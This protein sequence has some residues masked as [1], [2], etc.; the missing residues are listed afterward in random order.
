MSAKNLRRSGWVCK[1]SAGFASTGII[2]RERWGIWKGSSLPGEGGGLL[3][4]FILC[5]TSYLS[6]GSLLC[7]TDNLGAGG[8]DRQMG[9]PCIILGLSS[10]PS[11]NRGTMKELLFK[12]LCKKVPVGSFTSCSLEVVQSFF[13]LPPPLMWNTFCLQDLCLHFITLKA[14]AALFYF[15]HQQHTHR[16]KIKN[17][18]WSVV[19][20]YSLMS[21][22]LACFVWIGV[23]L[24][25][26]VLITHVLLCNL[27]TVLLALFVFF[28]GQI[29]PSLGRGVVLWLLL[30]M[31]TVTWHH[32]QAVLAGKHCKYFSRAKQ[33][34]NSCATLNEPWELKPKLF[35][36]C[37]S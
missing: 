24:D 34:T 16:E 25:S 10:L 14:V 20:I 4:L 12:Y 5:H 1:G 23:V 19:R 33:H 28:P 30:H 32:S 2:Q 6:Q 3:G 26:P 27:D 9:S 8:N 29:F 21:W 11:V 7:V 35:E 36:I 15:Y 31:V 22:G 13:A 17:S 18:Q 37:S